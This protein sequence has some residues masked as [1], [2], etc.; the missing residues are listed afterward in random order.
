MLLKQFRSANLRSLFF[1]FFFEVHII[2]KLLIMVNTVVVHLQL[3][4][5][6]IRL[7]KKEKICASENETNSFGVKS[8]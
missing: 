2:L 6:I 1:L 8:H 5:R 3:P 4:K 7:V